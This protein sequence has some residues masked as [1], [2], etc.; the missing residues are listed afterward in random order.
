MTKW[1]DTNYHYLVPELT[2]RQNSPC[3]R[4]GLSTSFDKRRAIGITTR[5]VLLGPVSFLLLSKWTGR[6]GSSLALS[7]GCV[8]C[9]PS[10]STLFEEPVRRGC[11][12]TSRCSGTD[13]DSKQRD[14]FA[15]AYAVLREASPHLRLLVATYFAGLG[16]NLPAALALP[17]DAL[18][19]DVVAD[20]QQL[21]VAVGAA[22]DSLALSLG[23]VDGRNV[24]RTDLDEALTRLE[25]ARR[26]L[27]SDRILV[28]PSCSLL[29]LPV[30]LD[31]EPSLDPEL[32]SWLAFAIQR[33]EEVR[34]LVSGLNDG[35]GAIA[36]ELEE[37]SAASP[38][39]RCRHG[40]TIQ[41]WPERSPATTPRWSGAPAH[42]R[43]ATRPR[44]ATSASLPYRRPP[45]ARS[46]RPQR[47][48]RFAPST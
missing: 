20:P 6:Q 30:D 17:V 40:S 11:R 25:A 32:R 44:P 38:P 2:P 21:E 37:A 23:I 10:C 7:P 22:P 18:H 9:T 29:H 15:Q 43:S 35:R 24:W 42:T 12:S 34:I 33:L 16:E 3:L 36:Q 5:P 45:S 4:R 46:P 8:R 13:L 26:S 31:L 47:S 1:F 41:R 19:L 28:A 39:E 27:G 48:A 14:A